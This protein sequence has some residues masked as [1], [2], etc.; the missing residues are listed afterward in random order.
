MKELRRHIVLLLLMLF[1]CSILYAN[2]I[3]EDIIDA[4]KQEKW[5]KLVKSYRRIA[6][7]S[8]ARDSFKAKYENDYWKIALASGTLDF[9]DK[10]VKYPSFV[11]F[12]VDVYNWGNKTFNTYDTDYVVGTGKNWKLQLKNDNWLDFYQM[13][14]PEGV[15]IGMSSDVATNVGGSISFMAVSLGY[16]VNLDNLI[17]DEPMKH[18]RLDFNF[19]C[20]LIALDAYYSKN[21]GNTNI[22]KLGDYTNFNVFNSD[23]KFSG[24][25]LKSYGFDL[26][27]FFNNRK[28]S[29]GAA[30]SYSKYQ[31]KS[32]GS[33]ISG[34]TMSHQNVMIDFNRLPENIISQLPNEKLD[35]HIYYNDFCLMLGYGYNWVFKKNWLLNATLIP[36]LGFNHSLSSSEHDYRKDMLS[37]N[38]KAKMALV[39]NHNNF[40]YSLNGRY[41]GH[42]YNA[43][44]YR[45]I[46]SYSN[47]AL[48]AGFRF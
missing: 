45:F 37:V 16:M 8:V 17:G 5:Y 29:Q 15:N 21:T 47:V 38:V 23:Y 4:E 7:D 22:T 44:R 32:A 13:R 6:N 3:G 46:N 10:S 11:Q 28:Y 34:I 14:F 43:K 24:L 30:Y 41:D 48:V 31:K 42:F 36:C 18:K 20:A 1:S 12:C 35:Y 39:Y 27:Y 25:S 19:S 2:N 26:Y 33:I 40:Y 9:E